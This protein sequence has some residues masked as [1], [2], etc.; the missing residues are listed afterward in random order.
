MLELSPLSLR[1]A[2]RNHLL[3]PLETYV[4]S[5][6]RAAVSGFFSSVPNAQPLTCRG[7]HGRGEGELLLWGRYERAARVAKIVPFTERLSGMCGS[8]EHRR[9]VLFTEEG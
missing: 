5:A 2:V 6:T 7:Q 4:S 1:T 3:M 9:L 8:V